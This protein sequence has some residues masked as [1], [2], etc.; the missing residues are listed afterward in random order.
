MPLARNLLKCLKENLIEKLVFTHSRY[1]GL[2]ASD[3]GT[4]TKKAVFKNSFAKFPECSYV[5][6]PLT[7]VGDMTDANRKWVPSYVEKIENAF[8]DFDLNILDNTETTVKSIYNKFSDNKV[9]ALPNYSKN[10]GIFT[11]L[12]RIYLVKNNK[13]YDLKSNDF[14]EVI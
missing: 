4:E 9:Y 12:E 8:F 7:L 5:I 10:R 6:T 14:I 3:L 2:K 13:I 1:V 11:D